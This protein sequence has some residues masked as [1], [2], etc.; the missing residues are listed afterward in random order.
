MIEPQSGT[1]KEVKKLT[2]VVN[3]TLLQ[4]PLA[5]LT[6]HGRSV[7]VRVDAR[8]PAPGAAGTGGFVI[9]AAELMSWKEDE[10]VF[11]VLHEWSHV[12]GNHAARLGS[13]DPHL[14]NVACDYRVNADCKVILNVTKVPQNG[15]EPPDWVKDL[16]AEAIYDE[17]LKQGFSPPPP[18]PGGL[19]DDDLV[20]ADMSD[21]EFDSA[22][23]MKD[24]FAEELCAAQV[25]MQATGRDLK[26][27]GD[28]IAN[29]VADIKRGAIPWGRLLLG[30]VIGHLNGTYSTYAPPR[31]KTWP[32]LILPSFHDRTERELALL[33]DVSASVGETVLSAFTSNITAAAM[34][35]KRTTV[36][37]FDQVIRER[38]TCRNPREVLSALKLKTGAHSHTDARAAFEE[39]R[40]LH[41][42]A[43]VCLT[44]GYISLPETPVKNTIFAVPRG[45][46]TPPWGK[47]YV[48][49]VAW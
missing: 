35:A 13:R 49:D 39:A 47:T 18:K 20:D 33:I 1:A 19:G 31:R 17:I 26:E 14:W 25:S 41:A 21:P 10:L 15:L 16:T 37:T 24:A 38:F 28:Y 9:R 4:F 30:D 48:M 44:D 40:K 42:S 8:A 29:R 11:L 5:G 23:D 3:S 27:F 22:E 32:H 7:Y 45:G 12:F 34:R 6:I 36:I 43:T 46:K 2:D